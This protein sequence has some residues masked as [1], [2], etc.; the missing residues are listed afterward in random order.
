L[1][2]SEKDLRDFYKRL[3]IF[4][5][6]SSALMGSFQEIQSSNRNKTDG[7][8]EGIYSYVRFSKDEKLIVVTNFSW[9][10]TSTIDLKIPADVI[11]T[12]KLKDGSYPMKEQLYG[13]SAT[14]KV[15]NGVGVVKVSIKPSESFILKL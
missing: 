3:L 12:W 10:T 11:A 9:L 15:E 2:Q 5:K 6:N 1:S 14:L 4:T 8:S 13:S 7:F